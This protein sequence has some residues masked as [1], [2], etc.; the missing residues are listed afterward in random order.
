[1][2]WD[3]RELERFYFFFNGGI[4]NSRNL[5][6]PSAAFFPGFKQDREYLRVCGKKTHT[7]HIL[8]TTDPPEW[9]GSSACV[10]SA[11][12]GSPSSLTVPLPFTTFSSGSAWLP[13]SRTTPLPGP[14]RELLTVKR[15]VKESQS[16]VAQS[17]PTLC[18][19]VDCSPPG[20][21]VHG[22]LQARIL[23]W[24]AISFSRESSGPRD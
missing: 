21:S 23:E 11:S 17:C 13:L 2:N 3:I 22:I 24:V 20:S 8:Y 1:M 6:H 4:E 10:F 19:P 7:F 18:D 16:E 5:P 15:K 9:A 14:H 12:S